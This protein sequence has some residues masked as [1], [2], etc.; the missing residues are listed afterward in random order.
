MAV[1]PPLAV[2][3]VLSGLDRPVDSG[4][5]FTPQEQWHVTLR[6]LG[7]SDPR[8]VLA[9][10]AGERFGQCEAGLGPRVTTLGD[11]VVMVPVAGL[12]DLAA[13]VRRSTVAIGK[14]PD[15]RFRGH[16]TLARSKGRAKG[17]PIGEPVSARWV[18]EEIEVVASVTEAGGAV[19]RVLATLP[20][21]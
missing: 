18:P 5:R 4:L 10:L 14:R 12:D 15:H 13:Q 11:R 6:F 16:L 3:E 9:V 2:Q 19:H 17:P 8:E 7:S 20:I 21:G 1:R